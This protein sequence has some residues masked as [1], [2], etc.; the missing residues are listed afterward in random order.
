MI[1]HLRFISCTMLVTKH[2]ASLRANTLIYWWITVAC[3]IKSEIFCFLRFMR[4]WSKRAKGHSCIIHK[5][6][7]YLIRLNTGFTLDIQ[8]LD[9]GE[10]VIWIFTLAWKA[11]NTFNT[12]IN[13]LLVSTKLILVFIKWVICYIGKSNLL[14][15]PHTW[16]V[17]SLLVIIKCILFV[18]HFYI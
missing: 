11:R 2:R 16:R 1:G 17:L 8:I 3:A 5:I 18:M 15:C 7:W 10:P 12:W 9:M 13:I 14:L 6:T 4:F